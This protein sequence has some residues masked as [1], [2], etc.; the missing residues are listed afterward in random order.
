MTELSFVKVSED[1]RKY[2]SPFFLAEF[3]LFL[4]LQDREKCIFFIRAQLAHKLAE[5]TIITMFDSGRI[6]VLNYIKE[7]FIAM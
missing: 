2:R 6:N 4:L 5:M 1:L 7:I 3:G